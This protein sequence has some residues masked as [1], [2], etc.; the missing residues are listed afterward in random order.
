MKNYLTI[1]A[2]LVILAAVFV[3]GCQ[4]QTKTETAAVITEMP[5]E[6]T[7]DSPAA[8]QITAVEE[9]PAE[10]PSEKITP[11][12]PL[13][14]KPDTETKIAAEEKAVPPSA[15]ITTE[16]EDAGI[17][18]TVNGVNILESDLENRVKEVLTRQRAQGQ[19]LPPVI[20]G[21]FKQ[22]LRRR[23]LPAMITETLME[24]QVKKE[25]IVV[26]NEDIDNHINNLIA[27]QNLSMDD[28]KALLTARGTSIEQVK[29]SIA[30]QLPYQKLIEAQWTGKI[31]VTEEDAN[32]FYNENPTQF[33][34]PEQVR[35][36]HILI[37]PDTSDP[38][39]DPNEAKAVAMAKAQDLLK[40]IQN[41]ADFATL[42]KEHSTCP[43]GAG[44]GDLSFFAK[45]Q[46]VPPFD[47]AAFELKVG[48]VSNIVET[49]YGYHI[50]KLTDHNPAATVPFLD[51]KDRII[52]NL[53]QQKQ[54]QIAEEYIESL[55]SQAEI[56]Y[57]PGKEPTLNRPGLIMPLP[58]Q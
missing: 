10:I 43:S 22:E 14:T 44:G 42:A 31:N 35:A 5:A 54:R 3:S 25:N 7:A 6:T 46:M 1:F 37:Q 17:A 49:R 56:I 45:G 27:Q 26:S 34:I 11:P 53:T 52:D 38:N 4:P 23:M 36:S 51:A 32:A 28:F 13:E 47:E 50:I 30:K 20:T 24:Q 55:K 9:A 8:A 57:P 19:G 18:V 15:E 2:V 48:Q 21:G 29:E 16:P 33:E 41:A 58:S 12:M 40:Q 39:T